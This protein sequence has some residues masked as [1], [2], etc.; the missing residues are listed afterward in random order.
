MKE[1]LS[2]TARQT[3]A[4]CLMLTFFTW[5]SLFG[6]CCVHLWYATRA[7]PRPILVRTQCGSISPYQMVKQYRTWIETATGS[8]ETPI[9]QNP[10]Y[11]IMLRWRYVRSHPFLAYTKNK[12]R[13]WNDKNRQAMSARPVRKGMCNDSTTV[14][15]F[16]DCY[17]PN[18]HEQYLEKMSGKVKGNKLI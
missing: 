11:N 7:C 15:Y 14:V 4:E 10:L 6:N 18:I 12:W 17:C 9:T 2:P 13:T 5:R 1:W 8:S 3:V 16:D